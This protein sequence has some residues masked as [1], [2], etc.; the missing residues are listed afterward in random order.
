MKFVEHPECSRGLRVLDSGWVK[1]R[2]QKLSRMWERLMTVT[3]I[4]SDAMYTTYVDDYKV[5]LRGF[6]WLQAPLTRRVVELNAKSQFFQ[7]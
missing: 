6:R 3:E 1:A 4:K 2:A 7:G 5:I